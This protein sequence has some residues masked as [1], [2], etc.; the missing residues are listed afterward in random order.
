[1]FWLFLD[2][3]VGEIISI[4]DNDLK[5]SIKLACGI[6]KVLKLISI[7]HVKHDTFFNDLPLI[8]I[9]PT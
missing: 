5:K 4:D 7:T 1:M 2:K 9:G 8:I 6:N 3:I